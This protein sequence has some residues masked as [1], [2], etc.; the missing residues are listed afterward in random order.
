M[1]RS[2]SYHTTRVYDDV[3]LYDYESARRT[4]MRYPDAVSHR[5]PPTMRSANKRSI[6]QQYVTHSNGKQVHNGC[7][8]HRRTSVL[9]IHKSDAHDTLPLHM[10]TFMSHTFHCS[11]QMV[12]HV[13][14]TH[15]DLQ[16]TPSSHQ[17]YT[18]AHTRIH[19]NTYI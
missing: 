5:D 12:A 7:L 3:M 2:H 14:I 9:E 6:V 8:T 18:R 15:C 16:D 17:T 11:S 4:S 10:R 1:F 13:S 19:T